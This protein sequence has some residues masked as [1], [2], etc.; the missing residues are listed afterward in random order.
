MSPVMKKHSFDILVEKR[1]NGGF[2]LATFK[3]NQLVRRTYVGY[4]KR[5]ARKLFVEFLQKK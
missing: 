4:T 5:E 1:H 2:E 3:G